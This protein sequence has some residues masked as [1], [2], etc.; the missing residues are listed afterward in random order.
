MSVNQNSTENQQRLDSHLE[1][2]KLINQSFN[3]FLKLR[4]FNK[5]VLLKN[6]I[7]LM[8]NADK[9]A[10]IFY[11]YLMASPATSKI[12]YDFQAKGGEIGHL[13]NKQIQHL[14]SFLSGNIDDSSADNMMQVGKIH[15]RY[16][17]KPV[18]IM[19]AYKLYLDHLQSNIRHNPNIN[20]EDYNT[21][22]NTITT[23]LFRDMGLMLEGYWDANID[24][25]SQQK[26][27]VTNLKNQI[28]SLLQ[29]I[30][31][32]LWSIDVVNNKP[33]Y[34]SPI[35]REICDKDIDSPIPCLNWT[36]KED[37]EKVI[38]AW[39]SATMGETVEVE[40]R[41]EKPNQEQRWF[42]RIFYPFK[43]AAGEV[44]R[45][46]GLMED[47]TEN[48]A[49]LERLN[50]LATT[51]DL[52]G[53]TNRTLFNDR[54]EQAINSAKRHNEYQVIMMLIDLDH[55]KEINDT[56]GHQAGDKIL[57]DVAARLQV[58]LRSADT[59]ARLGGD[60]F[61]ILLPEVMKG[62][63]TAIKIAKKIQQSFVKPFHYNDI[64]LF[65]GASVGISIYPSHG[66]DVATLMSHAD[67]AMYS[68]K[69][70]ETAYKFYNTKLNPNAQQHL[71]LSSNLRH[72]LQRNELVLY[73]QP[74]IDLR[75]N[76]IVGMEALIRWNHPTLGLI[77]PDDFIPLAERTG[78]IIPIT[79]WVIE[80]AL[81]QSKTWLAQGHELSIAVNLS[82]RSFQSNRLIKKISSTL[83]H[84]DIPANLLEIEIT[85]NILFSDIN[86]IRKILAQI[87]DL[88][89]TIAIDDFGTG[90]SSLAYL[91][92]L[93]LDTLKIDK[94]FVMSM[95]ND[96]NDTVIVRSTIEL[97]HNLGFKVVAEGVEQKEIVDLLLKFGCDNGQGYYFSKPKP[98][99]EFDIPS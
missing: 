54:F 25:L 1:D 23:L 44:V 83:N 36:I 55:F 33:L 86:N 80:E 68:T 37:K 78:L 51:D 71:E 77:P 35:A 48:K 53:L 95:A 75:K 96:Q 79:E 94:S 63:D 46:D 39:H 9:F 61:G 28:T 27:Q 50:I 69:G 8:R 2:V 29:N 56:L 16:G 66:D 81:L 3:E 85:E 45:I 87:S 82:A 34:V 93:P 47:I 64:E 11:D 32:L 67:V 88:G 18:W 98:A 91:K 31:Q 4:D 65:L 21:L 15:H 74:K 24:E 42:R 59:L 97:A 62:R 99:D 26:E 40:S 72:A 7:N 6:H 73:Y 60:E 90:Y 43:N 57:I 41:V 12:L 30:P 49:T 10:E 92:S 17:I 52:T 70:T 76:C 89:V 5:S 22:E 13:I 58:L 14:F 38:S 19:G 84:L 20:N